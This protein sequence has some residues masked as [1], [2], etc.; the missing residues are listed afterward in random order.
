[1]GAGR[2][3]C[4]RPARGRRRTDRRAARQSTWTTQCCCRRRHA[5][6]DPGA[7][8]RAAAPR[9]P[10]PRRSSA[11]SS[12]AWPPRSRG[13]SR[14]RAAVGAAVEVVHLVGG[15]SPERAALPADRGR[16]RAAGRGRPGRGDGDGQRPRPGPGS[17]LIGVTSRTCARS[18]ADPD[19]RRYEPVVA[20]AAGALI[21]ARRALRHLLQRPAVPGRR[22]GRGASC[23]GSGRSRVPGRPDVLRPDPLQHRL[24]RPCV[25]LVRALRRR[26]RGLRR[27]RDAVPLVRGDGPSPPLDCRGTR[28]SAA[29]PLSPTRSPPSRR[30]STS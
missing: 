17:R 21:R 9:P 20:R 10:S 30:G 14:C 1:M 2:R 19:L 24:P 28:P 26:V 7:C 4:P 18:C 29:T 11:A 27:R 16:L 13:P 22:A 12:T 8:R 6:A 25:P 15:G 3:T 23:V 5:R